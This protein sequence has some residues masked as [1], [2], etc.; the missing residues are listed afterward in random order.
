[1]W[2]YSIYTFCLYRKFQT[3]EAPQYLSKKLVCV[4]DISSRRRL[5]SSSTSQLM[6]PCY[7]PS[8]V[9]SRSFSVAGPTIWNQ[10]PTDITLRHLLL[11][12]SGNSK[13][14]S[15]VSLILTTFNM[16]FHFLIVVLQKR[17]RFAPLKFQAILYIY[18]TMLKLSLEST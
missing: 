5:R 4:A 2:I 9:G 6:V 10:L 12:S 17:F 16:Y 8:T 1:M 15:F 14:I 7:W 18:Y 11:N 13:R 3:N